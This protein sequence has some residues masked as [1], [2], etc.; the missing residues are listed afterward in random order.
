[1][2]KEAG[3]IKHSGNVHKVV[4]D[5]YCNLHFELFRAVSLRNGLNN[6]VIALFHIDAM[7]FSGNVC[8]RHTSFS[9]MLLAI[10]TMNLYS[11]LRKK[12]FDA[13]RNIVNNFH[14]NV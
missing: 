12:C 14:S 7:V 9:I 5:L 11:H 6:V 10:R 3:S 8:S 2:T 4:W 13:Q 1:M